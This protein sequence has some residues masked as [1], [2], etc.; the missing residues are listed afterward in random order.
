MSFSFELT[1]NQKAVRVEMVPTNTFLESLWGCKNIFKKIY[2]NR[3]L[4]TALNIMVV[5][6]N[7]VNDE[8][9]MMDTSRLNLILRGQGYQVRIAPEQ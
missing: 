3:A 9:T 2:N 8:I 5:W 1:V 6:I 4:V 7:E